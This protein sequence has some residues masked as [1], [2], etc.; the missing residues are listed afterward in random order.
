MV[1]ESGCTRSKRISWRKESVLGPVNRTNFAIPSILKD[2][3]LG[4][5]C[6]QLCG[7]LRHF[8][9]CMHK[10]VSQFSQVLFVFLTTL[11]PGWLLTNSPLCIL[12]SVSAFGSSQGTDDQL[13]LAQKIGYWILYLCSTTMCASTCYWFSPS[14]LSWIKISK[15]NLHKMEETVCG[16]LVYRFSAAIIF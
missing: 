7:N 3:G 15:P 10:S 4:W 11:F 2:F 16:P 8:N 9:I 5:H 6:G 13:V 14:Q 1:R 12:A